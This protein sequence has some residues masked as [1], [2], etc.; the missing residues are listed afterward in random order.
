MARKKSDWSQNKL[1]RYLQEDRGKGEGKNY[2]PWKKIQDF[3]S[4]GRSSRISG[5]KTNRIHHFFS[6]QEKKMFFFLDWSDIVFDIREHYPLQDLELAM[7]IADQM[8]IKYPIDSQSSTPHILTTDFMISI[9]T[10]EGITDVARTVVS[11]SELMKKRKVELLE[12]E[13]RYYQNFNINWGV[14]T[15]KGI[16]KILAQNIEWVHSSYN[17]DDTQQNI[18][19][20]KTILKQELYCKNK[21]IQEI[22]SDLDNVMNLELG[23]SLSVFKHLLARKEIYCDMS[24]RKISTKFSTSFIQIK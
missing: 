15:E 3:P 21:S 13:R 16:S 1:S 23:T 14:V 7:K 19:T 10:D 11:S 8:G 20:L 12:L 2:V 24:S 6:D 9:K 17:L 18:K 5:W 22:T 4:C